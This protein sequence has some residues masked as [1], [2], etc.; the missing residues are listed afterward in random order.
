LFEQVTETG[1]TQWTPIVDGVEIPDQPRFL[2][3]AGAFS[4]VPVVIG[5]TRD[6]GWT[7]VNRSFPSSITPDQYEGTVG[8]EFGADAPAILA[9]YPAADFPSPKDALVRLVGDVEYTCEAR[10]IARLIER[11]KTPVYLYS[12]DREIDTV[13]PDRVAHGMEVNFVFGN[14]YGPPLFPAY[15]LTGEDL[16]LSQT[17]GGY[18]TRFAATGDPNTDDLSII[19][20]PAFKHP[21]GKGRGA[22]KYLILDTTITA[23]RRL[24]ESQCDFWERY[25][26]RSS[27]G[28]VPA[29]AP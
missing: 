18:W 2:Y 11:T 23:D 21:S 12:F 6:E 16:T 15:A 1:R 9:A 19:H 24:R 5:S 28:A 20:W 29:A 8:T 13:V 26:F 14:D 22:D 27:T 7:W 17:I 10:R 3:E 4:Q 25:F